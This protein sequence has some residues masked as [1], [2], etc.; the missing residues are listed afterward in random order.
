MF[1]FRK[2]SFESRYYFATILG[3]FVISIDLKISGLRY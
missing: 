3:K 1:E 2:Y